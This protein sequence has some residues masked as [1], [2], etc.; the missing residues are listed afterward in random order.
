MTP[1][2]QLKDITAQFINQYQHTAKASRDAF[3]HSAKGGDRIPPENKIYGKEYQESFSSAARDLRATAETILSDELSKARAA[4]A[5]APSQEA[6]NAL[7]V[8]SMRTHATRDDLDALIDR[9]GDNYSA[10]RA[11]AE[12]ASDHN[13]TRYPDHPLAEHIENL[14]A[15]D[16]SL[17]RWMTLPSA[18]AGRATEGYKALM[19]NMIDAAFPEDAEI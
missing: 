18:D 2:K 14:D 19:D 1:N 9:Y 7:S 13:V 15:L 6:V 12:Y 8:L 17:R 11:I 5:E 16:G 10:Y 4:T 3:I